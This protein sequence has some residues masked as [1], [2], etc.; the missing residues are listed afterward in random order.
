[1]GQLQ[2]MQLHLKQPDQLMEHRYHTPL[3]V[4]TAHHL[5]SQPLPVRQL[6]LMELHPMAL[7]PHM[8]QPRPMVPPRLM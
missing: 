6:Q 5:M 8:E 7:L 4:P 2:L 3:Q 1:M